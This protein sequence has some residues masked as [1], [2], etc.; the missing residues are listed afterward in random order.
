MPEIRVIYETDDFL[1]LNKPAGIAVHKKHAKDP[2]YTVADWLVEKYPEVKN[3]GDP[4]PSQDDANGARDPL[5]P[6][7][8]H[9]LDKDTSGVMLVAKTQKAFLYFKKLFKERRVEKEYLALVYGTP[10]NQS[11][12]ITAP[13]G[14][15]GTRQ[16][17]QIKGKTDLKERDAITEYRVLKTYGAPP[18]GY[19]LIEVRPKTGRT[20]QIRVHLKSIGTPI[21]C[22]PLYASKLPCPAKLGRLFLHAQRLSFTTPDGQALMVEADPPPELQNFLNTLQ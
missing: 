5:R 12:T 19:S 13:L 21:V 4:A 10:K 18:N 9:R 14:K 16:T 20:H 11:G 6:G 22:D 15:L 2:A 3:V 7:I 8:V 17:T 1:I